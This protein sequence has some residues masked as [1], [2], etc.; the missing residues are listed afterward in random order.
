MNV[1]NLLFRSI[2]DS[3]SLN[4]ESLLCCHSGDSCVCVYV[5][6]REKDGYLNYV[7]FT[8]DKHRVKGT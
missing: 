2:K 6:K 5:K 7:S 1:S 8:D 4:S 3:S